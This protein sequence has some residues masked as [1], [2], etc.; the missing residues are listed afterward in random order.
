MVINRS[1]G[2]SREELA[3]AVWPDGN[4]TAYWVNS[5]EAAAS[6]VRKTLRPIALPQLRLSTSEGV[7]RLELPPHAVVD[8][9]LAIR[10]MELAIEEKRLGNVTSARAN[11]RIALDI[12]ERGFLD[13]DVGS[14][15]NQERSALAALHAKAIAFEAS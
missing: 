1:R 11:A 7:Y 14:W 2:V 10:S 15:I 5:L 12:A 6:G 13:G 9:E 4:L 3:Q 8:R